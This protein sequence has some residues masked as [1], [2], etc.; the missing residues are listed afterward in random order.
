L[1][2]SEMRESNKEQ[3]KVGNRRIEVSNLDKVLYPGGKFTKAKVIDYYIRISAYLLPH[4]KN[5]P[6]TLKRFPDGVFGEFF[7][8]KDTP[9]FTP[10]WVRTFAVPRRETSGPDIRYVLINDLATLVWLANLANL[11]IHPFLHRAPRIDQPT[12]I[13]FDCDP[14]EGANIITCVKVAFLLRDI[15]KD[16]DFESFAK[17]SGSKGLQVYVP[18]NSRVTYKET[19]GLAKGVAE[20]LEQREP[21]LIVSQMAK[22]LRT[23]KVFIDWSQNAEFK[24]TVSVYSL[25][26]KTHRPYVS[27]P[28]EWD[29][30]QDTLKQKHAEELFFT[31]EAAL[32]RVEKFG[33]LFKPVLKT[34]QKFPTHLREYFESSVKKR[35]TSKSPVERKPKTIERSRQ[36]SRRRF[37]IHNREA[38]RLNYELGL[39]IDNVLKS[40]SIGTG[41]PIKNGDKR[42]AKPAADRLIEHLNFEDH[43]TKREHVGRNVVAWDLGTYE[44]VEG[45]YHKGFLRFYLNGSKLQGEWTLERIIESKDDPKARNKWQLTKS[46]KNLPPMAKK[47]I[48]ESAPSQ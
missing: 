7:Y 44:L 14:G 13:V 35:R 11:E 45:N 3:V 37:V 5:R 19:G 25:R 30:L 20:L 17:V 39:E 22:R 47:K 28:I 4:L 41:L 9:A 23:N 18:L 42:L 27:L 1:L 33:D 8:E 32:A 6:V 12:S 46:D 26:A 29:E 16:L 10:S 43:K 2:F 34:A 38:G 31:P 48:N 15:L 21:K 36:G 24:T 40:W